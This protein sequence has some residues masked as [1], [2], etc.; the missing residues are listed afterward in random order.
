MC[1]VDR[2]QLIAWIDGESQDP[3]VQTH[4]R[5]CAECCREVERIRVL[6]RDIAGYCAAVGNDRPVRGRWWIAVAAAAAVVLLA[7]ALAWLRTP[8]Q[9]MPR[10]VTSQAVVGPLPVVPPPAPVRAAATRPRPRIARP[11]PTPQQPFAESGVLVV[12]DLEQLLPPG[13]A[14]PGAVLVGNLTL[15]DSRSN[16]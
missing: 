11:R 14:P 2:S 10:P 5:G 16:P 13:A 7:V 6:S 4:V 15:S 9:P 3:A 1:N 8:S 12:L